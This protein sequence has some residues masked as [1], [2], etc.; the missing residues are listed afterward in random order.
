MKDATL[1]IVDDEDALVEI[2]ARWFERE[3]CRLLTAGNG[4]EALERATANP[5]DL[6]VSDVRMPVLD[7]VGLARRLKAG[8]AHRPEIILI[9]GFADLSERECFD[10]GVA[11][12]LNKPIDRLDLVGAARRC[13]ADRAALWREPPTAAPADA[14]EAAFPSAAAARQQGLIAVGRGGVCVRSDRTLPVGQPVGLRLA[15]A[16]ERQ[17]VIGQGIVRWTADAQIGVEITYVDDA[18]RA[19]VA[20]LAASTE[21]AAF[22]PRSC[23]DGAAA[24]NPR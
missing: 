9:T 14:L 2:F 20:Q 15:F 24:A 16:A 5:V 3:G 23:G 19:W 10:L 6:V 13:L 8:G 21:S 11:A 18:N 22:I 7:G 12:L 1:L 17:G 4:A